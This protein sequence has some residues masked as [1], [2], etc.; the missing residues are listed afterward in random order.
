MLSLHDLV[1]VYIREGYTIRYTI[2]HQHDRRRKDGGRERER[3]ED[4]RE[5]EERERES[6]GENEKVV[7]RLP[8]TPML[9]KVFQ[10]LLEENGFEL[11]TNFRRGCV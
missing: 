11:S 1:L 3:E 5:R 6:E 8:H 2:Q 7:A 9:Q 10:F 4:R